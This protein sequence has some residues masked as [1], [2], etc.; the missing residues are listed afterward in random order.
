MADLYSK[1]IKYVG[2]EVNFKSDVILHDDG[3]GVAYIKEWNLDSPAKPTNAQLNALE[4]QADD[5]EYNLGQI[6]KRK[7]EYGSAEIQME[8]IIEKGLSAEQTRVNSIKEKY[9][10]R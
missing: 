1:I 4:S 2:S 10:K 9:P 3:D 8:N 7:A 6:A 5:Y